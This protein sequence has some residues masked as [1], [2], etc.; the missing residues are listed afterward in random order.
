MNKMKKILSLALAMALG[1]SLM[2][3]CSKK[4]EPEQTP[5]E[6]VLVDLTTVTDPVEFAFG[7]PSDTVVATSGETP[8]TAGMLAYW[9]NYTVAT[10]EQQAYAT[11]FQSIDWAEEV[12]NGGTL[13]STLLDAAMDLAAYYS[14]MEEKS[15]PLGLTPDGAMVETLEQNLADAAASLGGEDKAEHYLWL[16]MTT[17]EQYRELLELSS[18]EGQMQMALFGKGAELA[19]TDAEVLAYATDELGY[20]GAKHILLV[21]VDMNTPVYNED[22]SLK[23]FEPLDE[24]AVAEKKALAEDVLAQIRAAADPAAKF[25]ELMHEYSEDTGLLTNPDGYVAYPGQMVSEFEQGAKALKE[26][27]ISELVE[28]LYGYHILMRIPMDPE[29][30]RDAK[31]AQLMDQQAAQ[32]LE[33]GPIQTNE[34]YAAIEPVEAIDKMTALQE[35]VYTELYDQAEASAEPET[36]G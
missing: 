15:A 34:A 16:N 25:D 1:L 21:T 36:E 3:G 20:Y 28:S 33:E 26:G 30:F 6:L 19:P 7:V 17:A 2:S 10:T 35:A 29:Q 23:G 4:E 22:G 31:I 13:A 5:E 11:G 24:A 9:F 8:I 32:W 27:E 18:L 14:L 12:E